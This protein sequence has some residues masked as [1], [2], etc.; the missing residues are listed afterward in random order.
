MEKKS[1]KLGKDTA[2]TDN[3]KRISIQNKWGTKIISKIKNKSMFK[4]R[5]NAIKDF[6]EDTWKA[7]EYLEKRSILFESWNTNY[8]YCEI[9]FPTLRIVK[10]F[11][12]V[13]LHQTWIRTWTIRYILMLLMGGKLVQQFLENI[14]LY[15][16]KSEDV[17]TFQSSKSSPKY[18][19][20]RNGYT[21]ESRD[22]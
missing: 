17:F 2:N 14:W 22:I 12:K 18:I 21:Y 4:K 3:W 6:I 20:G 19:P 15:H 16:L 7:Y 9:P 8:S 5:N 10:Y 1:H 11:L 13:S